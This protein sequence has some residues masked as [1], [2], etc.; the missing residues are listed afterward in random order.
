MNS[1]LPSIR[2]PDLSATARALE[3]ASARPIS[4]SASA[5]GVEIAPDRRREVGHRQ[6]RNRRR[7][8]AHGGDVRYAEARE[9]ERDDGADDDRR[10]HVRDPRHEAL[11]EPGAGERR[12]TDRRPSTGRSAAHGR[13]N[14]TER[15]H[16]ARMLRHV[17]A[18]EVAQLR[19]DDQQSCAGGEADDH[20]RRDEVDQRAQ[21]RDAEAEL[22]QPDHQVER[23]HQRH[24]GRRERRGKRA[25]RR[26]HHQRRRVGRDPKRGATTSPTMRRRSPAASRRR[27]RTRAACRRASRTRR[28]AGRR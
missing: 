16:E 11:A 24:V 17:D 15:A 14:S 28:P 12:E 19:A 5:S 9:R 4:V 6:R 23:Q 27:G 10:Q 8:R 25:D 21:P 1:W 2:W 20:R 26:E 7:Q 18:E 3:I 13:K 22:D